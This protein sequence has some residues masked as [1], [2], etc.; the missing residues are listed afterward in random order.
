MREDKSKNIESRF[1]HAN[2]KPASPVCLK[3]VGNQPICDVHLAGAS[4][5]RHCAILMTMIF[6]T[7]ESV[8]YTVYGESCPRFPYFIGRVVII[9]LNVTLWSNVGHARGGQLWSADSAR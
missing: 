9:L 7:G 3:E 8:P 4:M 5:Q 1:R 6:S 2:N